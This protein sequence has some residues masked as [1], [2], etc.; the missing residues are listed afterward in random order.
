MSIIKSTALKITI[1]IC[2]FVLLAGCSFLSLG[3]SVS[4]QKN[5]V[6]SA[7]KYRNINEKA[8][9]LGMSRED[10]VTAWGEP[11]HIYKPDI[12]NDYN[13]FSDEFWIYTT[14]ITPNIGKTDISYE[15]YFKDGKVIKII[16]LT[17][18]GTYLGI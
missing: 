5:D 9:S 3:Q 11:H 10:V 13:F 12:K 16:E 17:W 15:V 8:I 1:L 7:Y 2:C 6:T 14:G 4:L 18:K